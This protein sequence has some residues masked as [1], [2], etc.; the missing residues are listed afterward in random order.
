LN[1]ERNRWGS[2]GSDEKGDSA[3]RCEKRSEPRFKRASYH[4]FPSIEPI[5]SCHSRGDRLLLKNGHRAQSVT[6]LH[7][8]RCETSRHRFSV[9]AHAYFLFAANIYIFFV[10]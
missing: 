10:F 1:Y 7:V 3:V 8:I 4:V 2:D 6:N 5:H 9:A